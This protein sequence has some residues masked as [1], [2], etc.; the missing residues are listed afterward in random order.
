MRTVDA[1]KMSFY[2]QAIEKHMAQG[3]KRK[4]SDYK[5]SVPEYPDL[6]DLIVSCEIPQ[7]KREEIEEFAPFIGKIMGNGRPE[8]GAAT[9][10]AFQEVVGG[11][12]KAAIIDWVKKNRELTVTLTQVGELEPDSDD[13][14]TL[15]GAQM[16]YDGTELSYEDGTPMRFT[17]V[18]GFW[19]VEEY[20]TD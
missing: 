1:G 9:P 13:T 5:I 17:G 4:R 6:E 20:F 2:K 19:Y 14:I 10:I 7:M 8:I 11:K 16:N 15:I 12:V 18:M 3:H